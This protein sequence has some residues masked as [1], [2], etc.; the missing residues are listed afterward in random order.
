[1]RLFSSTYHTEIGERS[2]VIDGMR[3]V[4]ILLVILWHYISGGLNSAHAGT[5]SLVLYYIEKFLSV[6][7]SGVDLFFV[8]S[9]FLI[10][11]I[12]LDNREEGH[13]QFTPV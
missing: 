9:G 6:G 12:L 8:L 7:W 2:R 10:G 4:A 3:G 5:D 1:M 11:G 13:R